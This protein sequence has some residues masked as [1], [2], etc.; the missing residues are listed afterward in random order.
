MRLR[1]LLLRGED[2]GHEAEIKR[3]ELEEE[4]QMEYALRV[5]WARMR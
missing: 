2:A 5:T 3:E 4:L 1:A